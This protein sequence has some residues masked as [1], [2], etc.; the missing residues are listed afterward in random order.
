MARPSKVS[1]R[2][3][4]NASVVTWYRDLSRTGN[5]NQPVKVLVPTAKAASTTAVES[6][7]LH[8]D[9]PTERI[10]PASRENLQMQDSAPIEPADGANTPAE[11]VARLQA[12]AFS[13]TTPM[14][15]KVN[16]D[17]DSNNQPLT[18]PS[19][20]GAQRTSA[21]QRRRSPLKESALQLKPNPANHY[22]RKSGSIDLVSLPQHMARDNPV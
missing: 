22:S 19:C 14:F 20:S 12:A 5:P 15:N 1:H 17:S 3:I 2:E 7:V 13:A 21:K 18:E 4:P 8:D 9:E 6:E 16:G 11:Q 10:D